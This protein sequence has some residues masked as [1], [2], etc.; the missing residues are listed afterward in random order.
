MTNVLDLPATSFLSL[1]VALLL[2]A[3]AA[4][5]AIPRWLRPEGCT[6]VVA[7]VDELAYLA[8]GPI[9][10]ADAIVSRL[11]AMQ[12]LAVAGKDSFVVKG[13]FD[14]GCDAEHAVLSRVGPLKL[15]II[16][17]ALRPHADRVQARLVAAGALVDDHIG[18]RMRLWQT[19]PYLLL[20]GLGFLKCQ[21]GA[22]RERPIGFLVAAMLATLVLAFAR[23]AGLDRCTRSGAEALRRARER[24][25][26]LRR[27]PTKDEV[28]RAVAL[29]GTE[30]LV[31][32]A[33]APLHDMRRAADG[34]QDASIDGDGGDGGGDGG[35]GGGCGG[36][37]S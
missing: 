1:Y 26:R 10:L 36:C 12:R 4:S 22:A 25:D 8:G 20:L 15:S 23:F 33:W 9:R 11:L 32:S 16:D 21:V 13:G 14:N 19:S 18:L 27:A 6:R 28:D 24:A 5:L 30:V 2:A 31:G 7:D 3:V 17:D 37:G 35:C 29:F 34:D